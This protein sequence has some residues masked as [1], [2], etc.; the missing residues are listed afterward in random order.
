MTDK[1]WTQ[2]IAESHVREIAEYVRVGK[3]MNMM[4]ES[5]ASN[6]LL[7]A[8]RYAVREED[9]MQL[10]FYVYFFEDNTPERCW[11][12]HSKVNRWMEL[13]GQE[14]ISKTISNFDPETPRPA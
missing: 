4:L 5:I 7:A 1:F 11:G 13:R 10:H 2:Q 8:I 9:L 14:G 12:S 6:D 3:R